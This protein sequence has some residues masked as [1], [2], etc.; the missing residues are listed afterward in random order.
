MDCL[1]TTFNLGETDL[2]MID[3][4]RPKYLGR[5]EYITAIIAQFV[6][7]EIQFVREASHLVTTLGR[8]KP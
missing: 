2:E 7:T 3:Q 1:I 8:A 5:T 4:I 6:A